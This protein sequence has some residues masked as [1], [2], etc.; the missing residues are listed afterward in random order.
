MAG[1]GSSFSETAEVLDCI[2][3]TGL[4]AHGYHGVEDFEKK[5]GQ[6]FS[7]DVSFWLN[8]RQAGATDN[9]THT[10]NYAEVA[11]A[12]HQEVTGPSRDLVETLAQQIA[13]R[14]LHDY[15]LMQQVEVTVHKP[16]AP[17]PVHFQDVTVT[18]RRTRADLNQ[19]RPRR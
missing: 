11:A 10:I 18:I 7:V 3:L 4:S 1:I 6:L 5:A 8:T 14:L 2:S 16:E 19:E 17:I 9:L 13:H 15:P 12:V